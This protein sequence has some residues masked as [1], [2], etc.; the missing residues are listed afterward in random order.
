MKRTGVDTWG[1]AHT[2]AATLI[3]S[4]TGHQDLRHTLSCSSKKAVKLGSDLRSRKCAQELNKHKKRIPTFS[5]ESSIFFCLYFKTELLW[6]W[7]QNGNQGVTF[8]RFLDYTQLDMHTHTHTGGILWT[9]DQ[10]VAETANYT[11]R[12]K[13]KTKISMPSAWFEPTIPAIKKP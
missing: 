3:F 6:R 7:S 10:P 2:D 12:N 1:L 8:L 11:A 4:C 9:S 5:P 13:N